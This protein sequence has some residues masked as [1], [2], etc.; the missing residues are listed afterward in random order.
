[1][2]SSETL[3]LRVPSPSLPVFVDCTTQARVMG[4]LLDNDTVSSVDRVHTLAAGASG[5][6]RTCYEQT[7]FGLALVRYGRV[8]LQD[9]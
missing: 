4:Q 1:M 9:A 8:S 2:P 7:P 6:G 3:H 5:I